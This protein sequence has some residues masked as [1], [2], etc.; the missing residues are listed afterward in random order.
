MKKDEKNTDFFLPFLL[1]FAVVFFFVTLLVKKRSERFVPFVEKK[2]VEEEKLNKRQREILDILSS[3]GEV[4]VDYLMEN[5]TN[6]TERTLRRDMKKL[7]EMGF[8]K[9]KGNTKGTRYIYTKN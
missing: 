8:S 5:I 1:L 3:K 9:K 7:E 4:T 2:V 6:V